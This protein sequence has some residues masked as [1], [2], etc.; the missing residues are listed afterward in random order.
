MA[1]SYSGDIVANIPTND[2]RLDVWRASRHVSK[3][4]IRCIKLIAKI[5][6]FNY[7][8]VIMKTKKLSALL[9]FR[10]INER[11]HTPEV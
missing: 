7:V 1:I 11:R 5:G 4:R 2:I 10:I 3:I 6:H 8:G 9:G